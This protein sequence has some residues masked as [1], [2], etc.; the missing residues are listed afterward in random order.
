MLDVP[1]IQLG[2]K[3]IFEFLNVGLYPKSVRVVFWWISDTFVT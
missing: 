2:R 3:F 1:P